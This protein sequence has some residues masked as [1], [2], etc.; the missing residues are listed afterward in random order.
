MA[1]RYRLIL[2]TLGLA[3]AVV[4]AQEPTPGQSDPNAVW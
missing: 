4:L 3:V 2:S 1:F